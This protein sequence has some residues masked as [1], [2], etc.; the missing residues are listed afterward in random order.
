MARFYITTAIDYSN[1]D[2]HLGHAFEKIG[3]DAIARYRRLAGDEVRFVIGMD[4]NS[5]TILQ[6]AA[7][8]GLTPQAWVDRLAGVF[9]DTW[10]RL[11][12]SH[13]DFIRTTEPRHTRAVV[14]MVERIKQAGHIY[15]GTYE[16]YYCE[17]CEAFKQEKDLVDGRCP[18]HP[19]REIAWTKEDNYFFK[20]SEFRDPLLKLLDDH[21]EFVQPTIRRNEIRN[22]L[23]EGLQ[24][25]SMSRPHRIWGTPFPD[26]EE[27]AVY[28][29]F[30]ALINYL[31]AIGFPDDAYHEWWPADLHVI[32]KGI[33]RFHCIM[34]P[35][36]LMAADVE[37]PR[38]VWAHGYINWEGRKLS[39]S[40]GAPVTLDSAVERYGPDPLRY[41]LLREIPWDGD[42]DFSWGRYDGIYN[43]ELANDLGNLANRTL[44]MIHKYRDAVVPKGAGTPLDDRANAILDGYRSAMDSH[45][46]HRGIAAAMELAGDANAYVEERAPWKQAKD[47]SLAAELDTTLSALARALG[48]LAI[49]L[50][51]IMPVK[52]GELWRALGASD[53]PAGMA[54][55][56]ALDLAG[57]QVDRQ[58]VLFPKPE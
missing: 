2:P 26:D 13:D 29:W 22:V 36:M 3:A 44:A 46:I 32:G 55:Y 57:R 50:S 28:V 35:A 11:G 45:L 30:D 15:R 18:E 31:S 17:R 49:L 43:A 33:T 10:A 23:K 53:E 24:D 25:I 6:P 21:P 51:P 40:A 56:A 8:A 16:G 54:A 9:A 41:F 34:W 14:E 39:K 12:I 27:H 37:L 5:Q 58:A 7:E 48:R 38:T 42:G 4:E 47:E 19:D 20:L 1:G 52:M